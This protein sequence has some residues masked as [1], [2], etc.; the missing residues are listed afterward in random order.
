V[1]PLD[2][3]QQERSSSAA[4][5]LAWYYA[6]HCATARR[7]WVQM[8]SIVFLRHVVIATERTTDRPCALD[9]FDTTRIFTHMSNTC[10]IR[11]LAFLNLG[12]IDLLPCTAL[13]ATLHNLA[14][15]N[16]GLS[17]TSKSWDCSEKERKTLS[18]SGVL[19]FLSC[20][21]WRSDWC[22]LA[23]G[24]FYPGFRNSALCRDSHSPNYQNCARVIRVA[25]TCPYVHIRRHETAQV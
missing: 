5:P 9:M 12:F 19:L 15:E 24:L 4:I 13:S 11:R 17:R 3:I 23:S 22:M 1:T 20:E 25:N 18:F 6:P 14:S 21:R 8:M 16:S 7:P 10:V 2:N